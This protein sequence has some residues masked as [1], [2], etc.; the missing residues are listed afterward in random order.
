MLSQCINVGGTDF[1]HNGISCVRSRSQL[2]SSQEEA[3]AINSASIIDFV[4]ICCFFDFQD[5]APPTKVK[6]YPIVDNESPDNVF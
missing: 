4:I 6:I 3:N 5:I 1:S 2:A